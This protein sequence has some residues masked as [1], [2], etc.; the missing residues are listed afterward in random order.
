[1]SGFRRK[2]TLEILQGL[3]FISP[4]FNFQMLRPTNV[5]VAAKITC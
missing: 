4:A 2:K 5:V 1:M 3:S